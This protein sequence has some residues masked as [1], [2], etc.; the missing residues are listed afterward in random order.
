M[1]ISRQFIFGSRTSFPHIPWIKKTLFKKR[2]VLVELITTQNTFYRCYPA[3]LRSTQWASWGQN[4]LVSRIAKSN[5]CGLSDMTF[6]THC[7]CM[8]Y[9]K[10]YWNTLSSPQMWMILHQHHKL[11]LVTR[12]KIRK[13]RGVTNILRSSLV[14]LKTLSHICLWLCQGLNILKKL[15]E[16]C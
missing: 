15:L 3:L 7:D 8:D 6:F 1:E 4:L 12:T 9:I 16:S 10:A 5:S 2:I 13:H 14:L 11:F